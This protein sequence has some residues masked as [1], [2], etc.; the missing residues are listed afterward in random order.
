MTSISLRRLNGAKDSLTGQVG[1]DASSFRALHE[2]AQG[3]VQMKEKIDANS[4][5]SP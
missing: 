3:G 5:A 4:V 2:K 1:K